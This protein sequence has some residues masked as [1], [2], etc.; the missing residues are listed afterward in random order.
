MS[1]H[2]KKKS[3]SRH[4]FLDALRN[5]SG[6]AQYYLGRRFKILKVLREGIGGFDGR[7]KWRNKKVPCITV[8]FTRRSFP[9]KSEILRSGCG[10]FFLLEFAGV[11][12]FF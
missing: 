10:R 3:L 8:M 12:L 4:A 6:A 1:G 7:H 2:C 9:A 5:V 11:L